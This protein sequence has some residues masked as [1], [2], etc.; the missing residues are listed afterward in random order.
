VFDS[1]LLGSASGL[2]TPGKLE[3]DGGSEGGLG[4]PSEGTGCQ[5][6]PSHIHFPSSESTPV[7]NTYRGGGVISICCTVNQTVWLVDTDAREST[8][9]QSLGG[10]AAELVGWAYRG[11]H[12]TSNQWIGFT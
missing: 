4:I 6:D 5:L 12:E 8:T 11:T 7:I 2:E 10:N 3:L 1:V 9:E